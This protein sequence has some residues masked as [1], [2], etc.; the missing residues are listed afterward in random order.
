MRDA[1]K[2]I[3]F[4][5]YGYALLQGDSRTAMSDVPDGFVDCCVTSP[6]YYN[7]RD[8]GV[9]GQIG[10]EK[11]PGEYIQSL[12]EV[13]SEVRRVLK[14]DGTLWVNIGDCYWN[15]RGDDDGMAG[16]LAFGGIKQKDKIGIPWMLAFALRNDGWYLRQDII[17]NKKNAQPESVKDRCVCAHEY[18]FMFSKSQSYHYDYEAIQE[19]AGFDIGRTSLGDQ[20]SGDLFGDEGDGLTEDGTHC[21]LKKAIRMG[22]SKYGD[23]DDP[24]YATRSGKAWTPKVKKMEDGS[25]Q[26]I[27]NRRDV[28]TLATTK[29]YDVAHF[30]TYPKQL[31]EPC[32]LAGC[33]ENGVVLDPFNGAGT[34]GIVA[35]RLGRKYLGVEL[36]PEYVKLTEERFRN[37]PDVMQQTLF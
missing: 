14:D 26:L 33:I 21:T 7:L 12:V 18:I 28:W 3:E 22:G 1:M 20:I 11:S 5:D 17:W 4:N 29:S 25:V 9:D 30:A 6:P 10:N 15:R 23:S 2:R 37:D 16:S 24:H 34:T 8:Y 32:I 35:M 19:P 13:F 31:V 36:N 27:R